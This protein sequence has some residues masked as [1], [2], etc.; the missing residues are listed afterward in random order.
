MSNYLK[1][2]RTY[3]K[4]LKFINKLNKNWQNVHIILEG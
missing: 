2:Y 4:T 3:R 1:K